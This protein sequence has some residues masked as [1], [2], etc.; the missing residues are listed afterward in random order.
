MSISLP[1]NGHWYSCWQVSVLFVFDPI[2]EA[3]RY[4]NALECTAK[5]WDTRCKNELCS[6]ETF[7]MLPVESSQIYLLKQWAGSDSSSWVKIA[8]ASFW[9]IS[10]SVSSTCKPSAISLF[11]RRP[12]EA[13]WKKW[14]K[15]YS[16]LLF[17]KLKLK[18]WFP[19]CLVMKS[20]YMN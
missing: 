16:E 19:R 3:I 1:D 8:S 6:S 7:S 12:R 4:S 9:R 13:N 15:V 10:K 5:G 2:D 11:P 14:K 20:T 17:P 18:S